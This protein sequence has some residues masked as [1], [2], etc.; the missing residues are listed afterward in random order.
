MALTASLTGE[1]REVAKVLYGIARDVRGGGLLARPPACIVAGGE[2]TVTLKGAGKGGRNQELA[3]AFLAEL[4]RDERGGPRHPFPVRLDGRHRR[5]H[6]C[7]R[8]IRVRR[9]VGSRGR[10]RLIHRRQLGR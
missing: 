9:G 7:R 3:L 2:T 8:R 4:A 5:P 10:G 6:G 1:A